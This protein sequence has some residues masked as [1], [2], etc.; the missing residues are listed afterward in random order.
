VI[1]KWQARLIRRGSESDDAFRVLVFIMFFC[2]LY[3]LS[4]GG[5]LLP[6]LI[7][8]NMSIRS[9]SSLKT[10]QKSYHFLHIKIVSF[11]YIKILLASVYTFLASSSYKQSCYSKI[12]KCSQ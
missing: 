7:G 5:H 11:T 1:G 4:L 2:R 8:C 12:V 3:I 9:L 6:C 10:L